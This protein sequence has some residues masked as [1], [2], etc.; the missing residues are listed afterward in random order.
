MTALV[1]AQAVIRAVD[2]PALLSATAAAEL[3]NPSNSFLIGAGTLWEIGIKVGRWVRIALRRQIKQCAVGTEADVVGVVGQGLSHI[4]Q[5]PPGANVID[6][7]QVTKGE[8]LAVGRARNR[9]V[10]ARTLP[11]PPRLVR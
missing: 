4:R 9:L 7:R 10:Q 11:L 6:V 5:L 3:Q 8:R 1:D 2:N